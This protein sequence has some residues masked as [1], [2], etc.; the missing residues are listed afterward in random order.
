VAQGPEGSAPVFGP[1][2]QSSIL[3]QS[4]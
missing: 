2:L 3:G 4:G 1:L